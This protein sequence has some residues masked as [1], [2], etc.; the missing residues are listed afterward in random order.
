M[1]IR[2]G[3]HAWLWKRGDFL[4]AV[5]V[6]GADRH[7]RPRGPAGRHRRQHRQARPR[8]RVVDEQGERRASG[9]IIVRSLLLVV[10]GVIFLIGLDRRAGHAVPP[11]VG[12]F[13]AGTFVVGK[14][15][16]GQPIA[17]RSGAVPYGGPVFAAPG[18][19]PRRLGSPRRA[20]PAPLAPGWAA[21]M[22]RRW[23]PPLRRLRRPRPPCRPH[24]G[25]P[26]G[27]APP[28]PPPAPPGA[29]APRPCR[30][31]RR[32]PPRPPGSAPARAS[33]RRTARATARPRRRRRPPGARGPCPSPKSWWDTAIPADL[34]M[35][36]SSRSA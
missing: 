26:P 28:A 9:A 22:P 13:A 15:S 1:C 17:C 2:I 32:R 3:S 5:D 29:P 19:G 8:A 20:A 6:A 18:C 16:A 27:A 35:A 31:R 30:R 33:P 11:P 4:I 25:A 34:R 24:V 10:D 23:A 21:P 7:T 36:K 14:A 12:D